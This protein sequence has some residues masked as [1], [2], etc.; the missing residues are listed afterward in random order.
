MLVLDVACNMIDVE[1]SSVKVFHQQ[2][3]SVKMFQNALSKIC[4]S[5]FAH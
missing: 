4:G 3:Y 5:S 2:P 1:P